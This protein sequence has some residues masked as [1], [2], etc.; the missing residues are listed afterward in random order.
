[1][2]KILNMKFYFK[3]IFIR[4]HWILSQQFGID[5]L[6]FIRGLY[7]FPA[8]LVDLFRFTKSYEG[9]IVLT[10]CLDDRYAEGGSANNEYFWQDL[11]VAQQ[12]FRHK[13]FKHVDVGSRIDGFVAHV[14]SFRPL[15]VFDIRPLSSNIP[16]VVFKQADLM[17]IESVKALSAGADGYCDSLS[18]L[19]AIE[20]FGLGRYGD[21]VDPFG[22]KK[23]IE[24]LSRL[25]KT[26]G[27][28]YLSTP[29]G[30]ERVEFNANWVFNPN[31]I[32]N[33]ANEVG[34]QLELLVVLDQQGG[35]ETIIKANSN[36]LEALAKEQYRL[37]IFHFIK[38]S[39][40]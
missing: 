16:G 28:L 15:E 20:H 13:P 6:K 29:I 36:S 40:R 11:L 7:G 26:G 23:G 37:G 4:M 9:K 39:I 14:A 18:C 38:D 25:L 3:K 10:P 19:H 27:R 35:Q 31:T 5:P 17:S 24:N 32:L 34:L 2:S 33:V 8:Y 30:I 12:I 22:Y 21:P 1:V